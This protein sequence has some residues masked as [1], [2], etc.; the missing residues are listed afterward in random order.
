M[1][2]S[3]SVYICAVNVFLSFR[4]SPPICELKQRGGN[5]VESDE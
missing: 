4:F 2:R 5:L 1:H 3:E